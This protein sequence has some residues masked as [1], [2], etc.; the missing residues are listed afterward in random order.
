ME[1]AYSFGGLMWY[2]LAIAVL[3]VGLVYFLKKKK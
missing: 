2:G 3:V 1:S